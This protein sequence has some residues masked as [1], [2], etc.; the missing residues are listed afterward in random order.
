MSLPFSELVE[1]FFRESGQQPSLV[2]AQKI[3]AT[4]NKLISVYSSAAGG[5]R[6]DAM[7]PRAASIEH[8]ETVEK[9]ASPS[10]LTR[11]V[12]CVCV[13][14][15]T[16]TQADFKLFTRKA[17]QK[18][19]AGRSTQSNLPHCLYMLQK[20]IRRGLEYGS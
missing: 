16:C 1:V 7:G 18:V 3:H 6:V 4:K 9:G 13:C 10:R 19:Y 12:F 17:N 20:E 8:L 5:N 15:H 2:S 11:Q 14:M